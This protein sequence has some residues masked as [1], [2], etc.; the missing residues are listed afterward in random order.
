M[1]AIFVARRDDDC[2]APPPP[3][4]VATGFQFGASL[5]RVHQQSRAPPSGASS[6]ASEVQAVP[7]LSRREGMSAMVST[8]IGT[9]ALLPSPSLAADK[10]GTKE[11]PEYK[12]CMSQCIY[13]C[14]KVRATRHTVSQRARLVLLLTD[15]TPTTPLQDKVE[16]KDRPTCIVECKPKVGALCVLSFPTEWQNDH[17]CFRPCVRPPCVG[18][19]SRRRSRAHTPRMHD[20]HDCP[21]RKCAKTKAQL[22]TGTPLP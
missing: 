14:T 1:H 12:A 7:A 9:A 19:R 20:R 8:L 5:D 18:C 21:D 13:F 4:S 11:D 3:L 22:L 6:R 2:R 17:H 15:A 16:S 10:K